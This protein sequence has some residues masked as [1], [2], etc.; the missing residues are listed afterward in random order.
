MNHEN[1]SQICFEDSYT[2]PAEQT[3]RALF[4]RLP[5]GCGYAE[6]MIECL[7]TG[8]LVAVIE[9][10]CIGRVQEHVH[11]ECEVVVGLRVHIEHRRPMPPKARIVLRG[12]VHAISE[13][14]VTFRVRAH[15]AQEIACEA[16][17]TLVVLPRAQ[18]EA[19]IEAKRALVPAVVEHGATAL[20]RALMA[21]G[22]AANAHAALMSV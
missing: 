21:V 22:D 11:P 3:A 19:R 7:A 5:H 12:W 14:S 10:I 8:Y 17:V 20:D 13:R 16:L 18:M 9:S 1:I 2:V 4:A 6:R 15:D